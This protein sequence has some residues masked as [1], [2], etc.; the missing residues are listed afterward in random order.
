[1]N[2][3]LPLFR[4]SMVDGW[5]GLLGWTIGILAALFL[6][7]PLYPSFGGNGQMQQ[8]IDTLPPELVRSLNYD[9]IGSGPGY[10]QATFYGLIGFVLLTIAAVGW[11]TDAIAADEENGQLELTLAHGV[12]R[13]QVLAERSA[14]VLVRLAWLAI[15]SVVVVMVLNEP[16][17][18]GIEFGNLVATAV[19]FLGLVSLT[20]TAAIG[21]GAVTGRRTW[22][23]SAGS[24]IAVYAYALNALGNQSDE[25]SWLHDWS[26]YSWA[27]GDSPILNGWNGTIWLNYAVVAVLLLVGWLA[28]RRRDVAV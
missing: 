27:Y 16:S 4:R 19:A 28:F 10:A 20:A 22:A 26:P 3:V 1:M 23:V 21:V 15:V 8:I 6:Y 2:R 9:Q 12:L 11:G 17:E 13:G 24:G 5:R 14:A 25:L 7:L 18:L